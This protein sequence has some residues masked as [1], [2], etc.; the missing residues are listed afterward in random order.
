MSFKSDFKANEPGRDSFSK[1]LP[2]RVGS[3]HV[4]VAGD[5]VFL[6]LPSWATFC[7]G[8]PGEAPVGLALQLGRPSRQEGE[9]ICMALEGKA[10]PFRADTA[11]P[12]CTVTYYLS[13]LSPCPPPVLKWHPPPD[14]RLKTGACSQNEVTLFQHAPLLLAGMD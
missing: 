8:W 7:P 9:N 1:R 5:R 3:S 4:G 2:C 10:A 14:S 13:I 6:G 11:V 12:S